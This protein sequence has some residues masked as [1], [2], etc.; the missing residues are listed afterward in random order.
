[1]NTA[2]RTT[3]ATAA[4]VA[5]A[6][7]P[8]A[9]AQQDRNYNRDQDR[10][11]DAYA[12]VTT[13]FELMLQRSSELV[14]TNVY[15]R[16]GEDFG[17]ISDFVISRQTGLID[18]VVVNT[19]TILGVGGREIRVPYHSF[20]WNAS[21]D[22]LETT[23]S[24]TSLEALPEFDRDRP[25]DLPLSNL[26]ARLMYEQSGNMDNTMR[27][28][29]RTNPND[30]NNANDR[31]Q[32][33]TNPTDRNANNSD[34][35]KPMGGPYGA[36]RGILLSTINGMNLDCMTQ[37]CGEIDD[38]LIEVS[39]GRALYLVI[40]PDENF[41]GIA[42][43]LRVAPFSIARWNNDASEMEISGTREQVLAAPEFDGDL[44][45]LTVRARVT[46]VY[47]VFNEQAPKMDRRASDFK[48]KEMSDRNTK[49]DKDSMKHNDPSKNRDNQKSP[50]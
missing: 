36:D 26:R 22:R 25:G 8:F 21:R 37:S 28:K 43:T 1:M 27:D 47:G 10:N 39:T 38:V 6:G 14:G 4:I 18:S 7:A 29:D 20:A 12:A 17:E 41:L 23:M 44:T 19:G 34:Y 42:D 32:D 15:T 13:E 33:R 11:P 45:P 50:Y 31:N 30:R 49:S 48:D 40:D 46:E 2:I 3:L 35:I 16:N 24:T 9:V 5:F